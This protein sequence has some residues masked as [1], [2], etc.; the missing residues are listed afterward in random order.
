[1][2]EVRSGTRHG[3][4]RRRIERASPHGE[5]DDAR[6]TAADL[7]ATRAD[8][9]VWQAIAREMED[10]PQEERGDSRPAHGPYRGARGHVERDDH[11][12]PSQQMCARLVPRALLRVLKEALRAV[13]P[14]PQHR[15]AS[16]ALC[17]REVRFEDRTLL[18]PPRALGARHLTDDQHTRRNLLAYVLELRLARLG[19][20]LLHSPHLPESS[21]PGRRPTILR[22][23]SAFRVDLVCHTGRER[24]GIDG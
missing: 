21:C 17:W 12:C 23:L 24:G 18:V 22:G 5:E 9:L 20:S 3:A 4:K 14:I 11:D 2:L 8:V 13:T 1:M 16:S 6:E 7:E 19:C 15:V 10:G